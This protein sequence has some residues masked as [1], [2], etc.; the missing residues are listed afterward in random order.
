[1]NFAQKL[2]A[3]VIGGG[4]LIGA[5]VAIGLWYL[6]LFAVAAI[7][8]IVLWLVPRKQQ[9]ER[10]DVLVFRPGSMIP[11]EVWQKTEGLP[12]NPS[13]QPIDIDLVELD[14]YR[15]N[16]ASFRATAQVERV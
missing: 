4:L 2:P 9:N 12:I 10:R 1:M 3:Y 11:A 14:K 15:N 6:A 5:V 16:W 13:S 8:F 7:I